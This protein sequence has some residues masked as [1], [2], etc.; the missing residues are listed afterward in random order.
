MLEQQRATWRPVRQP[1]QSDS[2][3]G[4]GSGGANSNTKEESPSKR[5]RKDG[6]LKE[7]NKGKQLNAEAP[8][9]RTP[10]APTAMLAM[11]LI[12]TLHSI[13][14]GAVPRENLKTVLDSAPTQELLEDWFAFIKVQP[15]L[16][17]KAVAK[18]LVSMTTCPHRS[19]I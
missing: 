11:T 18:I 6:E 15:S 3:L 5:Q 7:K 16:S 4:S 8:Q 19:A 13:D 14:V 1:P 2:P 10:G 12:E 17:D 9:L